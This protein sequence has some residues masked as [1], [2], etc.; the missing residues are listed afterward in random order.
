L[1]DWAAHS[2]GDV[3]KASHDLGA[4]GY[5][6]ADLVPGG[7][8][9]VAIS[10][11]GGIYFFEIPDRPATDTWPRTHVSGNPSD[12]GFAVGDIDGD[13][14]KDIAATTGESK[15]VE[16]YRNPGK[17]GGSWVVHRVG[18]VADAVYLD[19]VEL[20]DLNGDGRL[21]IVVTEENGQASGAK[22]FWWAQPAALDGNPSW[23]R[24][25]LTTQA[26][27]HGLDVADLDRNG[28][29]DIVT[30][31]HRGD[32]RTIL[33]RNDG[34]GRF[35]P[36]E[37]ARGLESHLGSR[38]HDLDGDGDLDVISIAWDDAG[39]L[40]IARNDSISRAPLTAAAPHLDRSGS[41]AAPS[42]L[43]TLRGWLRSLRN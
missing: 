17:S 5:R 42:L 21:D 14:N 8:P 3:P 37:I 23:E 32:K 4:Q 2:I 35:T 40:W 26:T 28:A 1:K 33:W 25:A 20:A 30:G 38:L 24:H 36:H 31:E 10:S 15:R 27:T 41:G 22:T 7:K 9:E 11:G 19:R 6:I 16:W 39:L 18:E 43:G 12:E 34:K 29:M 13:G